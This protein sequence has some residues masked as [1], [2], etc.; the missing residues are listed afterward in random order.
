DG[1]VRNL[2]NRIEVA[3]PV[4]DRDLVARL[5]E[6]LDA[7]LRDNCQSWMLQPDGRYLQN[8]PAPD[9]ERFASQLVLLERLAGK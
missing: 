6:D 8:H 9:E 2:V 1:M 4:E 7:C 3:F 5:K